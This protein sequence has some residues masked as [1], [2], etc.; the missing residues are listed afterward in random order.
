MLSRQEYIKALG[1]VL[2]V[3]EDFKSLNY[4]EI[5]NKEISKQY[6]QLKLITGHVI[7]FDVTGYSD[8]RI[9]HSLAMVECGTMP[10]NHVTD[11]HELILIGKALNKNKT[12]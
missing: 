10:N 8:E 5:H 1:D 6:L 4:V 2:T 3:K 9:Y 7:V 11:T 12:A